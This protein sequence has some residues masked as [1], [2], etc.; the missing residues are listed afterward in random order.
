MIHS[1]VDILPVYP[2]VG[3]MNCAD[4]MSKT[5]DTKPDY[6]QSNSNDSNQE[7]SL[8]ISSSGST[9]IVQNNR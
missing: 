5:E 9:V 2:L 8:D 3:A 4:L 1:D 6:S 7:N